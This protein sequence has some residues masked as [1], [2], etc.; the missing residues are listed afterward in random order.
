RA[1]LDRRT[2]T[3]AFPAVVPSFPTPRAPA[4]ALVVTWIG[5]SSFLI[6][7]G[8]RNL[9]VDPV[10]SERASPLAWIGPRRW[11]KPGIPFAALPPIDAVLI[12]HDHYDHL[13]EQS[14]R[15]L[16]RTGEGARG[17]A[18]G[19]LPPLWIVPSGVGPWVAARGARAVVE[20]DWWG[21]YDLA[22]TTRRAAPEA[23]VRDPG[24]DGVGGAALEITATPAQ[25]FSGRR[26]NNR[27]ETLWCG[28][29]VR[30]ARHALWF[31]GDTGRHPAFSEIGRRLGPFDVI[32][33]PIG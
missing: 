1:R 24:R 30:S 11:A 3:H 6:Q 14:A 23:Q 25:H 12:S 27:N 16:N 20:L 5:H 21:R 18:L 22:G 4:D 19:D 10:W 8:G 33:M 26:V 9:L 31:V 32:F 15:Q 28:W 7:I 2:W 17:R 29:V 13:D